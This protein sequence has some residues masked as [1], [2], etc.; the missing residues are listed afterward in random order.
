MQFKILL[1]Y[2]F[3]QT[4]FKAPLGSEPVVVDLLGFGKGKASINENYTGRYWPVFLETKK[5]KKK[6]MRDLP[7]FCV[8]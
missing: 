6:S 1:F 7:L 8:L 3:F 5:E 2:C 4:I